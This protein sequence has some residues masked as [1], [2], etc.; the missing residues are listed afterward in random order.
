MYV[1][2]QSPLLTKGYSLAVWFQRLFR[3]CPFK[4][5][6]GNRAA[7]CDIIPPPGQMCCCTGQ[8]EPAA[9]WNLP[10]D[11]WIRGLPSGGIWF[12]R[13]KTVILSIPNPCHS[14]TISP[15]YYFSPSCC[16]VLVWPTRFHYYIVCPTF[17]Q[18]RFKKSQDGH[19]RCMLAEISRDLHARCK[20]RNTKSSSSITIESVYWDFLD[21]SCCASWHYWSDNHYPEHQPGKESDE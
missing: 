18:F 11:Y 6:I 20:L 5:F 21:A 12:Y 2:R 13:I 8:F 4:A 14:A 7:V 16:H 19:I 1:Q 15:H 17:K 10:G 3:Q 9:L